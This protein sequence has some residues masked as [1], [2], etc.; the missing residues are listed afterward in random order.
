VK[1]GTI[2]TEGKQMPNFEYDI[3]GNGE[4]GRPAKACPRGG[5]NLQEPNQKVGYYE[6]CGDPNT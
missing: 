6:D 5:R 3:A 2:F 4:V 1:L